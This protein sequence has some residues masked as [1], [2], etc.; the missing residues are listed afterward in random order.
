MLS[1]SLNVTCLSSGRMQVLVEQRQ[2]GKHWGDHPPLPSNNK[3]KFYGKSSKVRA[4]LDLRG[5]MAQA[6]RRSC[7]YACRDKP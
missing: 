7:G 3:P 4:Y 6:A 5:N 2:K 1:R